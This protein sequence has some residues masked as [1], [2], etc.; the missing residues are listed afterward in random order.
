MNKELYKRKKMKPLV[1]DETKWTGIKFPV[2]SVA[3][4]NIRR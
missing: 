3:K 2:P 1:A 4:N